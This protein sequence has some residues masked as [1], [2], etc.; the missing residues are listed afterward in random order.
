MALPAALELLW[1]DLESV[2]GQLLKE[3]DGLSQVQAD[4]RAAPGDWS[5]GEIVQHLTMAEIQ[6]GK[7]TSK[8]VKEAPADARGFPA[9]FDAITPLPPRPPGGPFRA[10]ETI[11]PSHGQPIGQLLADIKAARARTRESL[12][13]L[14]TVDA[15]RLTWRHPAFGELDIT[16]WWLLAAFHDDD[17]LQQLRGVKAAPGFPRR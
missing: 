6:T 8:L 1:N 2:R 9:D 13:R 7:L 3:A 15:R 16:Q 4:W 11:T 14:G 12:G 17:H 10:P 5:V